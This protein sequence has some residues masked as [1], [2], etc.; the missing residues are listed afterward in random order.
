MLEIVRVEDC[1][2][3]HPEQ[4]VKLYGVISKRC[5]YI[6][7]CQVYQLETVLGVVKR[8]WCDSYVLELIDQEE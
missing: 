6:I 5:D 4:W 2:N 1:Q 8:H 3:L 7:T